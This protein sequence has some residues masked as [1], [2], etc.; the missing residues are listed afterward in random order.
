M[1]IK[2]KF[3]SLIV[4]LHLV[5]LGLSLQLLKV[6]VWYFLLAE[7]IVIF[8]IFLS[9]SIYRQF[10]QPLNLISAGV[11][12]IKDKDF[13]S[14]F[15]KVGQHELDSLIDV[16]NNMIEQ[17][18]QERL[19]Q[20]EQHYFLQDLV[21]SSP[22]GIIILNFDESIFSLNPAARNFLEISNTAEI[23]NLLHLPGLLPEAITNLKDGSSEIVNIHNRQSFRIQKAAFIDR[24][25]HRY[26]VQISELT[27]EILKA[28]RD[29]NEKV[30]RTISH[31]LN[32]S[33]G[34]VNSILQSHLGMLDERNKEMIKTLEIAIN[35]NEHLLQFMSNFVKVFRLDSPQKEPAD[36]N[37]LLKSIQPL[38]AGSSNKKIEWQWQL[39]NDPLIIEMDV[40]QIEQVIVNILKN[41]VEALSEK[42]RI[43][44]KTQSLPHKGLSISNNGQL[45]TKEVQK[46]IF[47][48]FYSTKKNGQGI[49][50]TL[51]A[52]IL[53]NH[54]FDF[55]LENSDSFVRFYI[56]F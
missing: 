19:Q 28:E 11:E 43:I 9:I 29:A 45:L 50:L 30:I 8:S 12:S 3:V 40:T 14:K 23:S 25:F 27:Q 47:A 36:I 18:R 13:T 54:D 26:F 42:S 55:G 20:E 5:F 31:E 7:V 10:V 2:H 15:I 41:A 16:Y 17:L 51:S 21:N 6:S 49:G 33:I 53:R 56:N 38:I 1:R 34:A 22:S 44:I 32:N 48:P 35:R 52:E 46:R 37:L 39:T 4:V 24:G